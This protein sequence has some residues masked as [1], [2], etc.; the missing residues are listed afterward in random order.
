MSLRALQSAMTGVDAAEKRF[1]RSAQH[2]SRATSDDF[3]PATARRKALAQAP[4]RVSIS[5]RAKEA[6]AKGGVDQSPEGRR[7][8]DAVQAYRENLALAKIAADDEGVKVTL[9][10]REE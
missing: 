2:V 10:H 7:A 8:I 5:N 1:G 6:E 9:G 3:D 4:D